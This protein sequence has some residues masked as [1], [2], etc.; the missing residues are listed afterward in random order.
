MAHIITGSPNFENLEGVDDYYSMAYHLLN[1]MV[2]SGWVPEDER[3]SSA[4]EMKE[5]FDSLARDPD[6]EVQL[7]P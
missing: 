3:Q 7:E 5:A 6:P 4:E 2:R 1:A